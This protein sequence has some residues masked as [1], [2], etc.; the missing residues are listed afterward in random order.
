VSTKLSKANGAHSPFARALNPDPESSARKPRILWPAIVA[1]PIMCSLSGPIQA[2]E[3]ANRAFMPEKM[4]GGLP[5]KTTG[6]VTIL[7]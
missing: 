3:L 6:I 5:A 1:P 7:S 4:A 2:S